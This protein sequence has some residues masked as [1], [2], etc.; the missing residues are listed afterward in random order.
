MQKGCFSRL[1]LWY[2]G[3]KKRLVGPLNGC[4]T[5]STVIKG[6]C[7]SF[8]LVPMQMDPSVDILDMQRA[9]KRA[10]FGHF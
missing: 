5:H 3:P 7:S 8:R 2:F 6:V 4:K 1:I 9:P 10:F